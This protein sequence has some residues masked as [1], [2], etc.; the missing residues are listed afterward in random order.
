M[1]DICNDRFIIDINI[2]WISVYPQ[3]SKNFVQIA[4]MDIHESSQ[5]VLFIHSPCKLVKPSVANNCRYTDKK[6]ER[7][8]SCLT[9]I[10]GSDIYCITNIPDFIYPC[11]ETEHSNVDNC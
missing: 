5:P 1:M 6:V 2:D 3:M 10:L 11:T 9:V 7:K 8:H 4:V